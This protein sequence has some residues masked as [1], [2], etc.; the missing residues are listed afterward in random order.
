M[1]SPTSRRHRARVILRAVARVGYRTG[2]LDLW[3][4][5]SEYRGKKVLQPR[6]GK[7]KA[8]HLRV[9]NIRGMGSTEARTDAALVE[10]YRELC[11]RHLRTHK[12]APSK[13]QIQRIPSAISLF[14]KGFPPG[15][16]DDGLIKIGTTWCLNIANPDCKNCPLNSVCEGYLSRRELITDV[17]T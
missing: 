1:A 15:E 5:R 6:A 11:V 12:K 14:D 13:I 3:A 16:I 9:T 4:S 8:T 7:G 17:R 2:F 10:A